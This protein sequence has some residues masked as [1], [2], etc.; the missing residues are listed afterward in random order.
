MRMRI[1]IRRIGRVM[2]IGTGMGRVEL[3]WVLEGWFVW[4]PGLDKI[5]RPLSLYCSTKTAVLSAAAGIAR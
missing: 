2:R 3:G 1:R 4:M 5:Q